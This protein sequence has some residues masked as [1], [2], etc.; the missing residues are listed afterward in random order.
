MDLTLKLLAA[1][2]ENVA[3]AD[4]QAAEAIALSSGMKLRSRGA[5]AAKEF[6]VS[7]TKNP[8]EI[9]IFTR[10]TPRASFIFQMC[11]DPN[12]EQNWQTIFQSTRARH[13]YH[14]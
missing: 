14:R 13:V 9:K 5:R 1:Y 6:G 7:V 2:V 10:H 11:T 4:P 3:N 12:S 8:G